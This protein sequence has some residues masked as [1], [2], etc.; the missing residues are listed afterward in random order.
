MSQNHTAA[1]V[2]VWSGILAEKLN[3]VF[4]SL[5]NRWRPLVELAMRLWLAQAFISAGVLNAADLEPTVWFFTFNY[6]VE[7]M[8]PESA[9]LLLIAVELVCPVLL[10][11]G[12]FSRLAAGGLFAVSILLYGAYPA[13]LDNGYHIIMLAMIFVMGPGQISLDHKFAPALASSALPLAAPARVVT[14]FLG[15][16]CGPWFLAAPR[17]WT[18]LLFVS[19][20]LPLGLD[21]LRLVPPISDQFSTMVFDS[22]WLAWLTSGGAIVLGS[23]LLLGLMTRVASVFLAVII[24]LVD[25]FYFDLANHSLVILL[26]AYFATSG[27]GRLT[28]D[29]LLESFVGKFFPGLHPRPEWLETGPRVVVVGG[30]FGGINAALGF[31][32]AHAQ[33]TLIDRRNYH[34]FQ[35]LLYQVATAI[36]SPADIASPIRGLLRG[37][38]NCRVILGEVKGVDQDRQE[39]LVGEDRIG[40]DY[41]VLATGARHSY[42][43]KDEWE[44]YAPGLKRIDDATDVRRNIL[45]AFE[46]AEMTQE[47]AERERL[48]TFVIVGGGP[49]GVELAGAIAELARHG[50]SGEFHEIDP[51]KAKVILV[52]S[53][54][55][56]LPSMPESL[57]EKAKLSLEALGV[58]VRVKSRV[59]QIDDQGVLVGEDRIPAGTAIWAA[60]VAASAAGQWLRTECDRA[61]RVIVHPDLSVPGTPNIFVIG[62][63]ASCEGKSGNPLPGLAAVAKQQ[64]QYIAKL[65]RSR[66]EGRPDPGAFSYKDYG[67]MATIG[68]DKAVAD[69]RGL[70]L[71]G[72]IA[73]WLWSVVHVAFMADMRNRVSV[74]MDWTWSYLTFARRI[75]LITGTRE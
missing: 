41:L 75:R 13:V 64:G 17:I 52:Q 50:M 44:P 27:G 25:W 51:T 55:R 63:T 60:G 48:M 57:S 37:R 53:A 33:V 6:P 18:A 23:L 39:V 62:D 4:V 2:P 67:S 8:T 5:S 29:T 21:G 34:L 66:A 61:G 28:L 59:Q 49:T 30:G 20:A 32:Y 14:T 12:L 56:V 71:S 3:N 26:L 65:I 19:A 24:I 73:W 10:I 45:M 47:P 16:V 11:I 38:E 1:K 35:P 31:K 58:E 70:R 43:G 69:L 68:R 72:T 54:P 74:A 15:N 42:F 36:L 40:F 46:K 7:L 9:A 22:Q